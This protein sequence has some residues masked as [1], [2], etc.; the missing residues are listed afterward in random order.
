M[1]SPY[2]SNLLQQSTA[3]TGTRPQ[4]PPPAGPVR[5]VT[6]VV[7]Q[8]MPMPVMQQPIFVAAPPRGVRTTAIVLGL[9]VILVGAAALVAGYYATKQASPTAREVAVAQNIA[10]RDAYFYGREN[11]IDAGRQAALD[12]ATTTGAL[13]ASI[14]RE[15]AW[16]A[17]FR[18]GQRAGQR[19]VRRTSGRSYG[20]SRGPS[21]SYPTANEVTSAFGYAQNLANATNA[22]VDVEIYQG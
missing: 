12:N 7:Q 17:A 22:P 6:H 1:T 5:S 4:S 18:R 8:P 13:R 10:T 16:S 21:I 11:G 3:E 19:S 15:Q 14:A 9:V 2:S 20:A